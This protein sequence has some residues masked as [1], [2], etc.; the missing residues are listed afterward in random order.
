MT[1]CLADGELVDSRLTRVL[2]QYRE[3]PKL[4]HLIR[5]FLLQL[6][7]V[8]RSICDLPSHFDIETAVGDQLTLLGKRLGWSRCHCVCDVQP[9]FGFDCEGVQ[10]DY[11]I[12]GLCDE[13]VTWVDCGAFGIGE[14]CINDDE[15]YRKF[16]KVRRHQ[17]MALFDIENL[18]EAVRTFWGDQALVLDAGHGRVVVA[19]GRDL[20][21]VETAL[22]QL[23]PRVL[24]VAPSVDVRFHF[25][26]LPVFG[27]GT[28]WGGFCDPWQAVGL[29]ILTSG[30]VPL[31]IEDGTE[32]I[33]GPLPRDTV[34]MCEFDT[35]PYD[36]I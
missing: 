32:I 8:E 20:S 25:G 31:V 17:M 11:P 1:E 24:P 10:Q 9:V 21:E 3:S 26:D 28:G 23:Y 22:L 29:P 5:T 18:N 16:L 30:D 13:A 2:T 19:P 33:T 4:L 14:V 36:C 34:W 12:A 35:H 6:E 7:D 27:F 15:L